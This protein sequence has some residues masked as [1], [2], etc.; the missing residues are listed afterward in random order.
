MIAFLGVT[1]NGVWMTLGL[2]VVSIAIFIGLWIVEER[3]KDDQ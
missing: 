3:E 1:N 2:A